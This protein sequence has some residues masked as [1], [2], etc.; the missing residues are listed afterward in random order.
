V[1]AKDHQAPPDGEDY[2][3]VDELDLNMLPPAESEKMPV[4]RTVERS[5]TTASNPQET[6]GLGLDLGRSM[7]QS[8]R[9]TSS[10]TKPSLH[11]S[12]EFSPYWDMLENDGEN[13][14]P[15][16]GR[17]RSYSNRSDEDMDQSSPYFSSERSTR[18]ASTPSAKLKQPRALQQSS[19]FIDVDN[20]QYAAP[21]PT[22]KSR[23]SSH[24]DPLI[25][26]RGN[27]LRTSSASSSK[28]REAPQF[29]MPS[30]ISSSG[31]ASK[32]KAGSQCE[33]SL[34]IRSAT[35][36]TYVQPPQVQ[37]NTNLPELNVT[38]D[39]TISSTSAY[40]IATGMN[41]IKD[42]IAIKLKQND[43][44]IRRLATR[45]N[46]TDKKL[47]RAEAEIAVLKQ[48]Q[49]AITAHVDKTAMEFVEDVNVQIK[50]IGEWTQ[51][52]HE[53]ILH[54]VDE[55]SVLKQPV[56]GGPF[57]GPKHTEPTKQPGVFSGM[58]GSK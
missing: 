55:A 8:K 18:T 37:P 23:L 19:L 36:E 44:L 48:E 45:L 7:L 28:Q 2:I 30:S 1:A 53:E 24:S 32:S 15:T 9:T 31:R 40:Q 26:R 34:P 4:H 25:D 10:S 5:S 13:S 12:T 43:D 46:E 35:Y 21:T 6:R 47:H 38:N 33:R 54:A 17:K 41:E 42:M 20:D 52:K 49:G 14:T 57:G 58:V 39:G 16:T 51:E 22:K 27:T 50:N 56:A 11:A 29:K 3:H